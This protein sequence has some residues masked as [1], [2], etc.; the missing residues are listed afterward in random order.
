VSPRVHP[1]RLTLLALLSCTVDPQIGRRCDETH[2][3]S[4]NRSCVRNECSDLIDVVDGGPVDAGAN[5]AGF[6]SGACD[7][8]A[9]CKFEFLKPGA[10]QRV[11]ELFNFNAPGSEIAALETDG[12]AAFFSVGTKPGDAFLETKR[13]YDLAESTF[14]VEVSGFTPQRRVYAL[15]QRGAAFVVIGIRNGMLTGEVQRLDA[16]VMSLASCTAGFE[17]LTQ[18]RLSAMNR[19]VKIEGRGASP[20][21]SCSL[22]DVVDPLGVPLQDL[23]LQL[24]TDCFAVRPD[25]GSLCQTGRVAFSNLNA[26]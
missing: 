5:D 2:P 8:S 1:A 22:P 17:G 23:K 25:G 7:A 13:T 6:D 14:T 3:C 24:G 9:P 18:L 16:G 21:A 4:A 11:L 19:T 20:D 26:P 15:F 10:Q 12:G